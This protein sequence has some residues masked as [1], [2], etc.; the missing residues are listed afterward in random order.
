MARHNPPIDDAGADDDADAD[1]TLSR[2]QSTEPL[3]GADAGQSSASAAS[4]RRTRVFW[5]RGEM[6]KLLTW[7]EHNKPD[8]IGHGRREE[9]AR[10][11][12]EVFAGRAD[13]TVK[14]I[15]EKLLNMEKKFKKAQEMKARGSG[16][17]DDAS[18]KGK[19]VCFVLRVYRLK[20]S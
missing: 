17:A 4:A 19:C 9:C 1:G 18:L 13:Y 8:I 14:T 10:I 20:K 11:K 6:D 7:I 15:K 16:T 5:G 2:E 12:D 3:A